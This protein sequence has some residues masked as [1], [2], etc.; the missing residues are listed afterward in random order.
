MGLRRG[1][2]NPDFSRFVVMGS[3][4]NVSGIVVIAV[5][6]WSAIL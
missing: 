2:M 6:S 5:M 3:G 4:A 1:Q